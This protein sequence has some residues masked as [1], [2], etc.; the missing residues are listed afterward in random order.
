MIYIPEKIN[1]IIG[2]EEYQIDD[3]GMSDST[4]IL[5]NDK[6]LKIEQECEESDNE[7]N[8]L[9]WLQGK[10]PVP[11]VL[12]FEKK[13]GKNYLLMSK[14]TGDMSC[15]DKYMQTPERLLSILADG[16]QMLQNVDITDCPYCSCLDI[17]LEMAKYNVDYN[18]V[19]LENV[20]QDTFSENGFKNPGHLLEWLIENKPREDLV[21]SH[22]DYCLP[23]IF[24]ND[25][26][27]NG[28]IDLGRAGI[29]DK[30]QDIALCYRSLKYDFDSKYSGKNQQESDADKLFCK[31]GIEPEWDKIRYYILLDELF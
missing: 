16:I 8:I 22:G 20:E 10:L 17:K 18:L 23:N 11:K 30:W 31:L 28:F 15:D 12:G 1:K 2:E 27:V 13:N 9:Q 29:A 4:V 21:F 25:D 3:I 24:V 7:H 6:V 5:F 14:L 26:R 19:D